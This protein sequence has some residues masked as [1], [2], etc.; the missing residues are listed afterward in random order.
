MSTVLPVVSHDDMQLGSSRILW[1]C[2]GSLSCRLMRCLSQ[3]PWTWSGPGDF[4]FAIFL[5]F[6]LMSSLVILCACWVGTSKYSSCV[7]SAVLWIFGV[8]HVVPESIRFFFVWDFCFFLIILVSEVGVYSSRLCV[9]HSIYL[10]L[11]CSGS[12]PLKSMRY[13]CQPLL[14][15]F[16]CRFQT[17]IPVILLHYHCLYS[18]LSFPSTLHFSDV[19]SVSWFCFLAFF[20]T[21][22]W[23]SECCV[24]SDCFFVWMYVVLLL[25][26]HGIYVSVSFC[27]I[28]CMYHMD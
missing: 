14:C 28:L 6:F 25:W 10:V 7:H 11:L 5:H 21:V 1:S 19:F 17:Y 8:P 18:G 4:Q 3:Y 24:C 13:S 9:E 27:D 15:I 23:N 16:Y 20:S 12:V 2:C 26:L 22:V